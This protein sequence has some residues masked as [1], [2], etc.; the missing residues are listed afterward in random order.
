M[1]LYNHVFF[2]ARLLWVVL[3]LC[4]IISLALRWFE[5]PHTHTHTHTHRRTH[6]GRRFVS[7]SHQP[8]I[9]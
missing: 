4:L 3:A 5:A 8:V 6:K 1:F 7:Y 2:G 9:T